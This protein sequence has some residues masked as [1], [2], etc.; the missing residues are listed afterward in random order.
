MSDGR[1]SWKETIKNK[2]KTLHLDVIVFCDSLIV[3]SHVS[4]Q[5]SLSRFWTLV[6]G[7]CQNKYGSYKCNCVNGYTDLNVKKVSHSPYF[8]FHRKNGDTFTYG[9]RFRIPGSGSE[10]WACHC[11]ATS[12]LR[13]LPWFLGWGANAKG[14]VLGTRL[15]ALFP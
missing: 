8:Y 9:V 7:I 5:C 13:P 1:V 10:T 15:T 6:L 14:E 4:M 12:F 2:N 3:H 11:I